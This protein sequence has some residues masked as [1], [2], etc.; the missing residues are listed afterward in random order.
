MLRVAAT[1]AIRLAAQA[2]DSLYNT[3]GAT[4]IFEGNLMQRHFQ[5]IHV[6]TQHMQG[7]LQH[8]E[9]IGRSW[10]GMPVDETRFSS[11]ESQR[12]FVL[13]SGSVSKHER[14]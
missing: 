6:I 11:G 9:M 13:R 5:D 4:A 10:L 1:H 14:S 3:A 2:V 8:Y 7:R 12:P